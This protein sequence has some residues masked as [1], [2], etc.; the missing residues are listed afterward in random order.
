MSRSAPTHNLNIQSYSFEEVLGL[1]DLTSYQITTEDIKRAKK[2]VLMLHPDKSHLSPDYFLFYKK[3]F[4]VVV[5]FYENQHRQSREITENTTKYNPALNADPNKHN[6]ATTNKISETVGKM[7]SSKTFHSTFNELFEK[8]QMGDRPDPTRNTWFTQEAA[9]YSV[10]QSISASNIGR[11]FDTIKQTSSGLVRYRGVQEMKTGAGMS[12]L[13]G[14]EDDDA[15]NGEYVASDPFSKLK[16]DDLRKVHKDQTVFA[17]READF[18]KVPTYS[19][20]D[21]F[22]RARSQHSY[23]PLAKE[24]AESILRDQERTAQEAIM[25]KEYEA[26]K[27]TNEFADKNR[28]ILASFLQLGNEPSLK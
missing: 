3:A 25:R 16:F 1:F 19:S 22:N 24:H 10:P 15:E 18:A 2:K 28:S 5:Q 9:M 12:K 8:N 14:D 11:E 27:R 23:E 20:V 13:Y 17:V 7:T 26:K 6:K 21:E 4:D